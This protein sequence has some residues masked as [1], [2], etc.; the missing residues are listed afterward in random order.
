MFTKH[1]N[2]GAMCQ[3]KSASS[4]NHTSQLDFQLLL[5]YTT[6]F[7]SFKIHPYYL[8]VKTLK[9]TFCILLGQL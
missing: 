1:A 8:R 5:G 6:T 4:K 2:R 7:D 9:N 3:S